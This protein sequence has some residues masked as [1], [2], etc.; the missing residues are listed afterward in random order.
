MKTRTILIFIA[1]IAAVALVVFVDKVQLGSAV[2][3]L[4]GGLAALKAKLFGSSSN[5]EAQ[6]E[7][8][9]EHHEAKRE[10]WKSEKGAFDTTRVAMEDKIRTLEVKADTLIQRIDQLEQEKARELHKP[11]TDEEILRRLGGN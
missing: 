5:L 10:A 9:D 1:V 6:L 8:I 11:L 3:A 2:A 4:F 7:E